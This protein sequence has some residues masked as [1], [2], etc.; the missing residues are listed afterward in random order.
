MLK[1]TGILYL[2]S[3]PIGNREDI[4]I[5]AIKTIFSVDYLLCEDTRKT[6]LLIQYLEPI[7]KLLPF[8][9]AQ[10]KHCFI[11]KRPQ[12]LSYF[13]QN[14]A[15]RIPETLV[16]LKSGLNVALVSNAGTPTISDPGFKLVRECGKENIKVQAIPG[17]SAFLTALVSSGLPTDKFFFLGFL[18]KKSL[19]KQ[20]IFTKTIKV[21]KII[22]PT[23]IAYDSPER[24]INSLNDLES[25]L[26]DIEIVVAREL[27]KVFEEIK[28]GKISELI[29]YFSQN[30]VKGEITLLFSLK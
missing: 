5:R 2:V 13:E 16:L 24:L 21:N 27:T 28:K 15:K 6:G 7:V 1:N 4:T 20:K 23:F 18:P 17:A 8:D 30:K 10:G 11:V 25:I 12:L 3:T 19:Q 29:V 14:E 26:G 22:E 9:F